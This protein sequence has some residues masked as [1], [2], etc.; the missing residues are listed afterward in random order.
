[1]GLFDSP[2]GGLYAQQQRYGAPTP[3]DE[4]SVLE[5]AKSAAG[6][7]LEILSDVLDTFGGRAIKGLL[8]GRPR[9]LLSVLPFS[10][11][12]TIPGLGT[13]LTDE[14]ER[15]HG[16]DLAE[17]WGLT[18]GNKYGDFA[19]GLGIDIA[20]DP[21]MYLFG[22]AGALTQGGRIAK[23]AGMLPRTV[24]ARQTSSLGGLLDDT[25]GPG[26]R[27]LLEMSGNLPQATQARL[28]ALKNFMGPLQP[29]VL[30][31]VRASILPTSTLGRATQAAQGAGLSLEQAMAG[32]L[33][34]TIGFGLPFSR[35]PAAVAGM[36]EPGQWLANTLGAGTDW[37][38]MTLPAR[39]L[40]AM[41]NKAVEGRVSQPLQEGL[42]RVAPRMRAAQEAGEMLGLGAARKL[43][44]L[45]QFDAAGLNSLRELASNQASI[46]TRMGQGIPAV[47][48]D[49][50]RQLEN[51]LL[52]E[53]AA[54][55]GTKRVQDYIPLEKLA[56]EATPG[57]EIASGVA[58]STQGISPFS[59]HLM[60][61]EKLLQGLPKAWRSVDDIVMDERISSPF[62]TSAQQ[63]V[64]SKAR[65]ADIIRR[66]HLNWTPQD[67]QVYGALQAR[68]TTGQILS[69]AEEAT[70]KALKGK[71]DKADELAEWAARLDPK[72]AALSATGPTGAEKLPFYNPDILKGLAQRKMRSEQ[73]KLRAEGVM[74]AVSK[75][76][77]SAATAPL[78]WIPA[79]DVFAK[80]GLTGTGAE[81]SLAKM[82][83]EVGGSM[84]AGGLEALRISPQL[85]KDLTNYVTM[86]S[87]PTAL[88][89]FVKAWD[90]V[91]YLFKAGVTSV[92]PKKYT[93]DAVQGAFQ[94]YTAMRPQEFIKYQTEAIRF[95]KNGGTIEYAN[96]VP[97]LEHMTAEAATKKLADEFAALDGFYTGRKSRFAEE[98]GG[99][100]F[101]PKKLPGQGREG[102]LEIMTP[103]ASRNTTWD[104]RDIAGVWG[105][106]E[107]K[108]APVAAG[109][110]ISE[111]IDDTNKFALFLQ[112]RMSGF[113]T[114]SAWEDV[115]KRQYDFSNLSGFERS[116]MRRAVPFYSWMRQN[117]PAT[118]KRLIEHP[119]GAEG[120]VA[121][122]FVTARQEEF[123]PESLGTGLALPL[124]EPENGRQRFLNK[125]WLP[126]EDA[127]KFLG[128]IGSNKILGDLT[129]GLKVPLELA[130]GEQL[131]TGMPLSELESLTGSDLLDEI[132]YNS[133]IARGISTVRPFLA[134]L[135][136]PDT[137][138]GDSL[139]KGTFNALAPLSLTDVDM[140]KQKRRAVREVLERKL[141]GSEDV[142]AAE[143][144]YV[145]DENLQKL[146]PEQQML[147]RVYEGQ[148]KTA[149]E[150]S[151]KIGVKRRTAREPAG[152][153]NLD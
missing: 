126:F 123:L 61:R 141:R 33:G 66:E 5:M 150:S 149:R 148:Q 52:S 107:T 140:E 133:P 69:D 118:I 87:R 114:Q 81:S 91:H 78:D 45:G 34:G 121:R 72:H 58:G 11:T 25:A 14:T 70:Y 152:L 86:F 36:G 64:A 108:Y 75:D 53:N 4:A 127:L 124:G 97:G 153:Y 128:N 76:A 48:D 32:P 112:R 125:S 51:M 147:L 22:P 85:T 82:M 6:S 30:A 79:K 8:G 129:P 68:K 120:R 27:E 99:L 117:V 105:R 94:N 60:A 15:V 101:T 110:K 2:Y 109:G 113:S 136:Y 103:S 38:G 74:Y 93:R 104:M 17:Q 146:S 12:L 138:V 31:P 20:T 106:T 139:M 151:K 7:G 122:S 50:S 42:L 47:A 80:I 131:H 71:W 88:D 40:R 21:I 95:V 43:D 116:I 3:H 77:Q 84:P 115:L 56:F 73:V 55:V 24:R 63:G 41:F 26:A 89:P 100:G 102:I 59:P 67:T 29:E 62:R 145:R 134:P 144:F 92:W 111:L 132:I 57:Y 9:E 23:A 119:G 83:Q 98:I 19:T 44:D 46:A 10:D 39:G 137:P 65:E 142:G 37:L 135:R 130:T 143:R 16:K 96:K 13:T 18:T 35:A 28:D 54:G 49:A 90:T 1:M